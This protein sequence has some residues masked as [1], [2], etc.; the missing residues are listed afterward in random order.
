MEMAG[1]HPDPPPLDSGLGDTRVHVGDKNVLLPTPGAPSPFLRAASHYLQ[2]PR[3]AEV[4]MF[5]DPS[6]ER[7]CH[8]R[9]DLN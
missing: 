8:S 6:G 1:Y 4:M 2:P 3:R 9:G 7:K 5:G